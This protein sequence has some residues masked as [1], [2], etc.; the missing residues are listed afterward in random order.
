ML[1]FYKGVAA[2]AELQCAVDKR[3]SHFIQIDEQSSG[4]R[5]DI[6][7]FVKIFAVVDSLEDAA[8]DG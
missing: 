4:T 8:D 1:A 2:D 5:V 3:F 7:G 6:Q